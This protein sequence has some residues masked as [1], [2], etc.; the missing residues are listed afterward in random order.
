MELIR[1]CLIM[2]AIC[3]YAMFLIDIIKINK[4]LKNS[5]GE[6]VEDIIPEFDKFM[7]KDMVCII[8]ASVITFIVTLI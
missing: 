6:K 8:L 4:T 3:L 5:I 2:I 7:N 1:V